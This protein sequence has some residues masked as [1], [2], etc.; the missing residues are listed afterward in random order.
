MRCNKLILAVLLCFIAVGCTAPAPTPAPIQTLAP[1]PA[2]SPTLPRKSGTIH[3]FDIVNVDVRD[4]PM[5]MALDTLAAQGYVIEKQYLATSPL[6]VDGLMRGD[7]D[8]GLLNNQT[9]WTAIAKG[10]KV[11]TIA[12]SVAATFLIVAKSEIKDCRELDGK[13][14]GLPTT[15]GANPALLDT[16]LKQNCGGGTPKYVVIP[17]TAARD[18]AILSGQVET[19]MLPSEEFLKVNKQAP[20]KFHILVPL[21]QSFPAVQVD[22]LHVRQSWA[23]QNPQIVKDFLRA[24]L[25]ANRRVLENPQVLYAE[26]VKRLGIDAAIAKEIGDD[27]LRLRIWD[28]NGGLTRENAKA[29]L[30]FLVGIKS[31]PADLK[32]DD[33]ADFSYLNAVLDEIGR[34]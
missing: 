32:V 14:L 33:I 29:T 5:L 34:K 6:I 20:G 25:D 26:S 18:A 3:F 15:T 4:V 13:S 11:R 16:Y 30:D 17:E 12:G 22:G 31:I 28:A 1:A 24:M 21:S 7:A 27:Y 23:E 8:I 19:V 10:A 2:P 9:M